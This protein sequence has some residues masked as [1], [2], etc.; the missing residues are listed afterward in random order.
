M[1]GAASAQV[2]TIGEI[3][4]VVACS[5]LLGRA[6][7]AI[8]FPDMYR[9][10]DFH[11]K[12]AP[13]LFSL[14]DDDDDLP[15]LIDVSE[16]QSDAKDEEEVEEKKE[17]PEEDIPPKNYKTEGL[18]ALKVGEDTVYIEDPNRQNEAGWLP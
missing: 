10:Y 2:V 17:N 12:D 7:A 5:L 4:D 9:I 14:E 8:S 11:C 3:E 15:D 6:I 13:P 16:D 18:L 1:G